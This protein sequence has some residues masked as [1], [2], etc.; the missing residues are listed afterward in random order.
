MTLIGKSIPRIESRDKVTGKALFTGDIVLP[1]K[2]LIGKILYSPVPHAKILSIDYSEALKVEGVKAIITS[3]DFPPKR[4]G[5]M[6]ED[7]MTIARGKVRYIGDR[8][9]AVAA[10]SEDAARE[11]LRKIKVEYDELPS[12]FDPIEALKEGAPLV[13]DDLISEG[14]AKK[15]GIDGN[16]CSS[17]ELIQG[18]LDK[19]FAEA[20]VV[21]EDTFRTPKIHHAFIE[22]H[23]TL[24]NWDPEKGVMIWTSSQGYFVIQQKIS[25]IFSLPIS[26]VKVFAIETGGGFGGKIPLFAEHLAC[27]LSKKAKAPVRIYIDR[28]EELRFGKPRFSSVINVKIGVKKDGTI[29]ALHSKLYYELGAWADFGPILMYAATNNGCGP[30][31]I[32]NAKL[33]GNAVYT[34]KISGAS[35]RA[36]GVPQYCFALESMINRASAAAGVDSLLLRKKNAVRDGDVRIS[37]EPVRGDS[38]IKVLDKAEEIINSKPNKDE[39]GIAA[40][41]WETRA[42]PSSILLRL[43]DDG[44]VAVYTGISDLTGSRTIFAQIVSDVLDIDMESIEIISP[45][46]STAP[47]TPP[48]SGSSMAFNVGY[49]VKSA[50]EA[51]KADIIKIAAGRLETED[52]SKIIFEKGKALNPES[53]KSISIAEVAQYSRRKL[54]KVMFAQNSSVAQNS[55]TLF[56]LQ[57]AEVD[58]DSETGKLD[59]KKITSIHDIGKVLN[60]L[61]LYGQVEGAVIQGFGFAVSEEIVFDDKGRVLTDN[62]SDYGTPTIKDVPEIDVVMIEG[63]LS[64]D[65]P[66][67]IK[68]IGE[69]PVVPTAPAIADAVRKKTGAVVNELPLSPERVF[70]ALKNKSYI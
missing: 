32:A 14:T 55:A 1:E 3:E 43:C 2:I 47:V 64:K 35:F 36:P 57:L 9:A 38:F 48:T 24:A 25:A 50:A 65:G 45:D 17:M 33:E 15:L 67:G 59:V 62:F 4:T 10:V 58:V 21:L 69:P 22:P 7:E 53:G 56:G 6:I 41:I 63:E 13:Q 28:D 27:A 70:K 16:L 44:R 18:D 60:P 5:L 46:T 20:D 34:N 8:V 40:C 30:Y 39:I 61:L 29:T 26:K 54:G 52:V 11:A 19:G 23:V 12:V 49:V 68:G 31:K 37:G 51:L 66:Y 42:A